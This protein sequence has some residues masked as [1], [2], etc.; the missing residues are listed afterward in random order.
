MT[1]GKAKTSDTRADL[2]QRDVT[3]DD[4]NRLWVAD[5]TYVKTVTG[6]VYAAFVTDVSS[7]KIV[8]WV[9]SDS[10]RTKALPLQA[11]NQ[12][13]YNTYSTTDLI[14]HADHGSQYIS[15]I[16]HE[17]LVE[18]GITQSTSNDGDCYDNALAENV[19][20]SYKNEL[21]HARS[22]DNVLEVEIAT[23][24]WVTW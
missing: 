22:R 2:V 12:A 10:M 24:Q 9:L 15:L 4:P 5:I 7:K 1:T 14:H 11:L 6:F 8:G 13:I 21:I 16:Y 17:R 20:G 18:A 3:A 23:F 19:N